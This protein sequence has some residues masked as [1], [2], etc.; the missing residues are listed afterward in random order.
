MKKI[1]IFCAIIIFIAILFV[2]VSPGK[3]NFN[4][5]DFH[6]EKY[7]VKSGDTLW[8]IGKRCVGENVDIRE[9]IKAIEIINNITANIYPG[10]SIIVYAYND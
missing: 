8:T 6:T 3:T 10:Q 5:K 4:S 1:Y 2:I 7:I 9:W